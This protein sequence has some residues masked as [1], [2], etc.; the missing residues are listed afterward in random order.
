MSR[1]GKKIPEPPF[2]LG[3]IT[4][5]MILKID[6]NDGDMSNNTYQ[7]GM[8]DGASCDCDIA[9]ILGFR[10]A[11]SPAD[12]AAGGRLPGGQ[13]WHRRGLSG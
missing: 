11:L 9:E 7:I 1:N 2:D 4:E 3:P 12:E 10:T 6:V 13:V 8:A 5:Y